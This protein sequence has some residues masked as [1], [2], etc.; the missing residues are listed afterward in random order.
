MA[1]ELIVRIVGD[2]RAYRRSLDRAQ[3]A[4]NGFS[5][6]MDRT[7]RGVVAGSGAFKS[8]GRSVAFASTSFLGGAG[9]GFA[10]TSTVKAASDMNE[11]IAKSRQIFGAS[12]DTI[13]DWS[14]TTSES[15]KISETQALQFSG[16]LGA[17]LKTAGVAGPE[18]AKMSKR[19]VELG[20]DM[21]SFNNEDPSE[22]LDRL[23]S[24]LAGE[25]EP[26]R[27][28]GVLLSEARVQQEAV[29]IGLVKQGAKLTE[30]QKV[31]SRYAIILRDTAAQ[32]GDVART[33]NQFAGQMR[34]L[35]AR[36]TE[37]QASLG[38]KL[39]PALTTL[40]QKTNQF[41]AA[42]EPLGRVALPALKVAFEGLRLAIVTPFKIGQVLLLGFLGTISKFIRGLE[43]LA[44]AA[45]HLPFVGDQFKGVSDKIRGAR[46]QVDAL[47]DSLRTLGKTAVSVAPDL[48]TVRAELGVS[49]R[50]DTTSL[51]TPTGTQ[52]VSSFELPFRLK[53]AQARAQVTKSIRDDVAVARE[54]VAHIKSILGTLKGEKLLGAL[55]ELASAQGVIRSAIE[56]AAQKQKTA[57]QK[58]ADAVKRAAEK[59]RQ[60]AEDA[61]RKIKEATQ[62]ARSQI[63]RLFE[64]P[65]L[66]PTEDQ[67][68]TALGFPGPNLGRMTADVRAQTRLFTQFQQGLARLAKIGAPGEL[69]RQLRERGPDALGQIREIL[70]G[71]AQQRKALFGAIR[72][73]NIAVQRAAK[74]QV[75]A[76]EVNVSGSRPITVNV[77]ME[78]D[79]EKIARVVTVKQQKKGRRNAVQRRGGSPNVQTA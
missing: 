21:A 25:A 14:K 69:I 54:I 37:L 66:A 35:S 39:I 28:F 27:R 40:V 48:A 73:Q 42:I 59:Q 67:R 13:R 26:L 6:D 55:S 47:A 64:G 72:A 15:L 43:L 30:Q 33:G 20:A 76:R 23:R 74:M 11:E 68:R 4:T 77:M 49:S 45:T 3:K 70:G 7:F 12:A 8:L 50:E 16:A 29:R 31:L 56:E 34:E 58:H 1:R 41:L 57:A 36:V 9:L 65:I 19:L 62:D 10:L 5:R 53:L 38:T 32:Q 46:E 63:G 24:G 2:E 52:K 18:L 51:T 78:A 71:T 61:A 22:M 17:M 60:A 75:N 79:G 44:D